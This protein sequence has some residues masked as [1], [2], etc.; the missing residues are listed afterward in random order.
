[1]TPKI[2]IAFAD[3]SAVAVVM[4]RG[5]SKGTRLFRWDS[6][7]DTIEPGS[8]LRGRVTVSGLSPDITA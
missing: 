8:W 1:M 5:P 3:E 6:N 4:R 7:D 2:E